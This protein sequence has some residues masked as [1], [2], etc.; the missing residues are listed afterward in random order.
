MI[1]GL[2]LYDRND[3]DCANNIEAYYCDGCLREIPLYETCLVSFRFPVCPSFLFI[4]EARLDR[5]DDGSSSMKLS[6]P[7]DL[8]ILPPWPDDNHLHQYR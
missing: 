5:L 7:K 1:E 2:S 4:N 8:E 3:K 6:S